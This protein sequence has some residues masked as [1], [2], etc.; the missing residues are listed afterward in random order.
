MFSHFFIKRPVFSM[1]ISITILLLGTIAM[2]SLP[3]ERYPEV[4]PPSVTVT[5]DYPGADAKTVADTVATVIEK[6]VN[7][8]E[9]MIYMQSVCGNNGRMNLTVTFESGTDL[10]MA[11]VLVQNRVTVA[12]SKLPE[13]VKRLGVTTKKKSTSA[14]VYVAIYSEDGNFTDLFLS[15]Y[16]NINIRDEIARVA[17]VGDVTTFGVGDY[18]IR[19]W[20]NPDRLRNLGM[21]ASDVVAAVREQN[22][23]VAAGQIGEPP[24][25][26]DIAMQY[27]VKVKGRLIKPA[28][29]SDIVLRSG[30]DGQVVRLK[31]VARIEL[32]ADSYGT[33]ATFKGMPS[34]V[35]A[36]YQIPGA[37]AIMVADGV[38][39]KMKELSSKFPHGLK[40]NVV[41][42]STDIIK[43]SLKEVVI[44]LFI[45]LILVIL[46]VYVFLQNFRAT[47]IPSVTIPVSLVG[48]FIV[49]SALGYSINQFTL[50]GLVLVIGIVVDDAI[51]VVEN[52]TRL[53]QSGK[54]T[55]VEAAMQAMTEISGPV[56]ATTLVLL[57]VFVPTA[58]MGGITGTLFK[59]FAVTISVATCFSTLNALT[60]SPTLCAL[61]LRKMDE[62]KIPGIFKGFNKVLDKTTSGYAVMVRKSMRRAA[63]GVIL[64]VVISGIALSGFGK[65]PTGFVPQEDEGFCIVNVQLPNAASQN[66]I[67]EFVKKTNKV[68]E[69]TPG[70]DRYITVTGYS[71]F[72]DVVVPNMA[73]SFAVFKDWEDRPKEEHQKHII[74]NLNRQFMALKDGIVY[75]I[76]TPSLPGLGLSGG[77]TSMLQDR[78]GV[79]LESLEKISNGFLATNLKDPSI[80]T[81]N[82]TFKSDVPQL[83]VDINRDSVLARGLT[84]KSV[85]DTMQ[86][87]L[88]SAYINDF[89]LFN[90]TFQVKAQAD[91][92]FRAVPQDITKL[93]FRSPGGNMV[94]L[95]SIAEVKQVFGPQSITHFNMYPSVKIMGSESAGY[96]SGQAMD[97]IE[98]NAKDL[99]S[100]IAV[101]WT[102]LSF[103]ERL[104]AGS[105][106]VIF[107][108]SV[109]LV[110]L[111]LAAQYESWTIP[112]AVCM[113][114]PTALAGAVVAVLMRGMD[115][116]VYTQVG[117]VLLIGL[118]T[119]T[120]IL[121]VEFA[122]VKH[123]EGMSV[124]DAAIEAVKLRFRAVMMTAFS[125]ILGVL[126]LLVATGA[127]AESRKVLGTVVFGGMMVAT[128]L[129]MIIVP[130][131][132]YVIQSAENK[133]KA[134]KKA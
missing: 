119:K 86:V 130:L 123:A 45:T 100:A 9:G 72:D 30:K 56:I 20:L 90:Q 112:I 54:Y 108:L 122:M 116:N 13:E 129:S 64:F 10:D 69:N 124:F 25:N 37:N 75:A 34:A 105:T 82:S 62:E 41:Y 48:T 97:T 84:M 46:T 47:I 80:K 99:P 51:V 110:Y 125:F 132:Y 53:L 58:F 133:A 21:N 107:L 126:P 118:S 22:M 103:Q 4:A 67:T 49:M 42:D 79:G 93:E 19:I 59:Q 74:D 23:Q 102:E 26:G 87:Y 85:F 89:T 33:T 96:S 17:G 5:A 44:T 92:S 115:N 117:I 83:K 24:L 65:L 111:V 73:F 77:F 98:K 55:P 11:N 18:S 120:A 127:G 39:D 43:A 52:A 63:L 29:F 16:L 50:C 70:V 12:T 71:M 36:V 66:R 128:M 31:D 113:A 15:N 91:Q 95:A 40:Y 28:E 57:A 7:G 14:S 109:I 101:A 38:K 3:V 104:A 78:G 88:G 76:P 131:I 6:E 60:L 94:P 81:M 32:G 1:V 68:L 61:L 27:T 2:L 121:I 8:V 114:V 134:R 106:S 35:M